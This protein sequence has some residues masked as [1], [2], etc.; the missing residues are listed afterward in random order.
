MN[1]DFQHE[2][3]PG[4]GVDADPQRRPGVPRLG[5]PHPRGGAYAQEPPKQ[6]PRHEKLKRE[7]LDEL[8]P[9]FGSTLPPHGLSG[10]MRRMAYRV[11][12]HH[13]KH[14]ALLL[15]ADRV[16][17][18]EHRMRSKPGLGM[19]AFFA[20]GAAVTARWAMR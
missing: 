14:W 16:D 10:A 12:E 7:S 19:L 9:V 18:L 17:V 5:R 6:I 13:R 8:T 20:V 15:L 1:P 2:R 3:I 11:P 4:W